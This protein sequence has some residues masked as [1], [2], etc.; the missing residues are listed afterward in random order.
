MSSLVAAA[1]IFPAI[2]ARAQGLYFDKP[3]R[4]ITCAIFDVFKQIEM[5]E[6][7]K[8]VQDVVE[9]MPFFRFI[10]I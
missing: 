4:Y 3:A 10:I 5:E 1:Q 9:S 2:P 8:R 7:E 6:I